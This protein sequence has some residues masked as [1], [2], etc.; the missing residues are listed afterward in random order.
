MERKKRFL[1]CVLSTHAILKTSRSLNITLFTLFTL[2]FTRV[3]KS[4]P[5]LTQRATLIIKNS[6]SA[7]ITNTSNEFKQILKT[8]VIRERPSYNAATWKYM[9]QCVSLSTNKDGDH[10]HYTASTFEFSEIRSV[11][12]PDK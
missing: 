8:D 9:S 5:N 1:E 3:K 2:R 4:M 7:R 12:L 10:S 11:F 6:Q